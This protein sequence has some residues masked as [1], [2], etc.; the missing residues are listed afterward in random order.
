MLRLRPP[1]MLIAPDPAHFG[2]GLDALASPAYKQA[3]RTQL[4]IF[5]RSWATRE[6]GLPSCCHR[7]PRE[8]GDL[9]CRAHPHFKQ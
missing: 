8:L 9:L 2:A 3:K 6:E 4:H 5:K 7:L 1:A